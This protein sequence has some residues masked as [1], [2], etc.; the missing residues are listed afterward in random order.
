MGEDPGAPG[1]RECSALPKCFESR[2]VGIPLPTP[3][4]QA[5]RDRGPWDQTSPLRVVRPLWGTARREGTIVYTCPSPRREI[6]FKIDVR[7]Q[8]ETEPLFWMLEAVRDGEFIFLS[9]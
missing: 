2:L 4:C 3:S 6:D 1:P 7:K 8:E 5:L 9:V